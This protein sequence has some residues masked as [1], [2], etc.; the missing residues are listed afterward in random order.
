M[1]ALIPRVIDGSIVEIVDDLL[2]FGFGKNI[3]LLYSRI[4]C[5]DNL[6]NYPDNSVDE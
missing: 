6:T 4:G 3:Q 2:L 1:D 5:R